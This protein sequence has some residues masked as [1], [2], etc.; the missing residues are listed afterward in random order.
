MKTLTASYTVP[1]D[2]P[3]GEYISRGQ[4]GLSWNI[5]SQTPEEH[6][7][8]PFKLSITIDSG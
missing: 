5:S 1:S 7:I 3:A 8:F 2:L 6:G 4:F